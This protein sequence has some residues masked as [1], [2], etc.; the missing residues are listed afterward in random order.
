MPDEPAKRRPGKGKPPPPPPPPETHLPRWLT[1]S[2]VGGFAAATLVHIAIDIVVATYDGGTTSLML[3][4][5]VGA[6]LA[7]D[8]INATRA[9]GGG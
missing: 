8:R 2:I 5:I 3:G 9:G 7:G 1:I 6:A 4:G